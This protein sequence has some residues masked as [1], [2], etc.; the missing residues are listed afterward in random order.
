MEIPA[1]LLRKGL[2]ELGISFT[3]HQTEAFLFYLEELK[4]W[5]KAY[6]LTG[7]T[8]DREI[9]I[10]HFLDSLLFLKALPE[11]VR[12]LADIGSGAGFPGIPLKIMYPDPV[13]YLVEPSKKKA[14]F[15]RHVCKQLRLP[16]VEIIDRRIE[17]VTDLK[18]DAAVT[19]ALFS[20]DDFLKKTQ[21][22]VKKKGVLIL[23]KGPKLAEELQGV[24]SDRISTLD[25]KLPLLNIIRHLVVIQA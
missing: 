18:V 6:N 25:V 16:D 3:E 24:P 9:I 13:V 11:H 2:R 19:R 15:L 23:S 14:A 1:D 4:R 8:T 22:I 5:N 17:E 21:G 20:I 7:L 12:S 10:K